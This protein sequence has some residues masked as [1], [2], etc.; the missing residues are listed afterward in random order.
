MLCP[1]S[2]CLSPE[3]KVTHTYRTTHP[4]YSA[5]YKFKLAV[6]FTL[7]GGV[8]MAFLQHWVIGVAA[9]LAAVGLFYAFNVYFLGA[10]STYLYLRNSCKVSVSWKEATRYRRYFLPD[11]T[12]R[13]LSAEWLRELSP[14][15]RRNALLTALRNFERTVG[16]PDGSGVAAAELDFFAEAD[17]TAVGLG[18]TFQLTVMV[19]GANIDGVPRPRVPVLDDFDQLGSISSHS[20]NVSSIKGR[21]TRQ[22]GISFVYYL[23]PRRGGSLT[24]PPFKLSF[25]GTTYETQ[26]IAV[27]A[28]K[29]SQ[30]SPSSRPGSSG[31]KIGD[32]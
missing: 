21:I 13:W 25:K 19:E 27:T 8:I 26:P 2:S 32:Y 31:D 16:R 10:L 14:S 23:S 18:E 29:Q 15:A 3:A 1:R 6:Y 11:D 22:N 17:R 24:I 9:L 5:C 4:W 7:V 30:A 12:G 28:T 20:T